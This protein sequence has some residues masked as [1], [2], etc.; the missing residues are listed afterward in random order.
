M[1]VLQAFHEGGIF[2][3]FILTFG[4]LSFSLIIERTV[5][6]FFK[7]KE[8]SSDFRQLILDAITRGD[9]RGA[10]SLA[11]NVATS[12]S[13]GRVVAVGCHL[14]AN[15]GA[16]EELQA[17]MD[18]KLSEEI[19]AI[20][21]RTGFLAMFG[22]VATLL[23]L[24]G[25][26]VGM[27]HSFAAVASASPADRATM[28]SKGI[29]EAM[30]CTAFGLVVAIP[31]L[32]AFAVFQNR[33]DKIVAGLTETATQIYHDL[34]FFT[35]ALRPGLNTGKPVAA[36]SNGAFRAPLPSAASRQPTLNA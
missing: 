15:A 29:S 21:Q 32:I 13:L 24:L 3:Y 14:R 17:R 6:L 28:L 19:S 27:I 9:L 20:D 1:N 23:G 7:V 31:A 12:T 33:T 4:I 16:D 10:E 25:T 8:P 11:K 30:N 18:E 36:D 34:L 35:E 26:I 22:N 5:F 2:M